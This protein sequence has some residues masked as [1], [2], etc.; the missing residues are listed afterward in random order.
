MSSDRKYDLVVYGATG[1]TGAYT[2]EYIAKLHDKNLKWALAGRSIPKL[3]KVRETLAGIDEQLKNLDLLVVDSFNPDSLDEAFKQAK[4]IISTVG[5]FEKYGTPVVESCIRQGTHYVDIT[6]EFTWA[7][8][9]IDKYH[10]AAVANGTIIVPFCGFDCVP[11]DMGAYMVV[12]YI[13]NKFGLDTSDVK[14]SVKRLRGGASGGTIQTSL[15]I[16]RHEKAGE[17]KDPYYL[18]PFVGIDKFRIPWMR[19]D[20]DFKRWQAYYIMSMVNE[21]VVRRSY[22][23][24][25]TRGSTYG[26]TFKYRESMSFPFLGAFA[27][28]FI[29]VGILPWFG[30]LLKFSPIYKL[31][32]SLL[33]Q[34]GTGPSREAITKGSYEL[35][36]IGTAETEPYENPIRVR[37]IVR[38]RMDPGYGDTCRMVAESALSIVYGYDKLPGKAGGVLT[39]ATAFGDVLLARLRDEG[40]MD[41]LI[42]KID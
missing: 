15:N 26:K 4:V 34:G 25:T 41:F 38:G 3:E 22:G 2:A 30:I 37:G 33:P 5:P 1:F 27:M 19:W 20:V 29:A 17:A 32:S 16:I 35:E 36:L 40:G 28:T 24:Y 13:R 31:V 21:L 8:T 23:I 12:N 7:K 6:G 39:P 9:I 10:D 11:S 42:E 18:S 14:L